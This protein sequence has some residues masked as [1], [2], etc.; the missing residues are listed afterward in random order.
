MELGGAGGCAAWIAAFLVVFLVAAEDGRY[1]KNSLQIVD[2]GA[3]YKVY[4]HTHTSDRLTGH[5]WLTR[6]TRNSPRPLLPE[7]AL[8][9]ARADRATARCTRPL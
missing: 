2:S 6:V 4:E 3:R 9:G 1:G 8:L 5:R 7:Q